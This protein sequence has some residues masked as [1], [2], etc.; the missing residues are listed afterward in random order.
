MK[1]IILAGGL[2]TRMSEYTN[3]IPKPMV[4]IGGKPILWH[5][6]N[7]YSKHGHKD[8]II[9][10]GYLSNVVKEY[11]LHYGTIN[12]DFTVNL[13]SG[14]VSIHSNSN[15]D[16]NVTLVDTG[17]HS[18]TGGRLKRLKEFVGNEPFM[19]TYGDGVANIDVSSLVDFHFSHGKMVTITAVRPSARFGELKI[20]DGL[21]E[22]FAEKP[23]ATQGWINGGFFVINPEFLDLIEDDLTIL[24][25]SP[26]EVAASRGELMAFQHHGFWQCM[27]TKRD[28]EFLDSLANDKA[29]WYD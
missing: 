23:Q 10:L 13:K 17:S 29:P 7:I 26:L 19:V 4:P 21:V 14:K 24:E 5:I 16:W 25:K 28:V 1:T 3:L 12:S 20:V 18:M 2:G 8:F 6:M 9:A 11:F 27:D 15:M 22:E